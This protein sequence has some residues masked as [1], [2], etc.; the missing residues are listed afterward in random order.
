M[1]GVWGEA[2]AIDR[3]FKEVYIGESGG[4]V[5]EIGVRLGSLIGV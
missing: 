2:A 3:F 4:V 1:G 5:G